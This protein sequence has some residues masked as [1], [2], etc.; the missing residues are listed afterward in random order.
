L[1]DLHDDR[2]VAGQDAT[3]VQRRCSGPSQRIGRILAALI[4][5]GT[6]T[7]EE[8]AAEP[9]RDRTALGE[10]AAATLRAMIR[11]AA[12]AQNAIE[13]AR[14]GF[15]MRDPSGEVLAAVEAWLSGEHPAPRAS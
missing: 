11:T 12:A 1:P 7:P 3:G 10:Q 13:F 6:G 15:P 4:A 14:Y 5:Q 8:I 2:S 9:A